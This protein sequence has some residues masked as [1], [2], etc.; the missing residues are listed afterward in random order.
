MQP[1]QREKVESL[2]SLTDNTWKATPRKVY[3]VLRIVV[4]DS[5]SG[6][7][8]PRPRERDSSAGYKDI[9]NKSGI[10]E[11]RPHSEDLSPVRLEAN[12]HN[13]GEKRRSMSTMNPKPESPNKP[14]S[15]GTRCL[16]TI[17][18]TSTCYTSFRKSLTGENVTIVDLKLAP[19]HYHEADIRRTRSGEKL[20]SAITADPHELSKL[21][22]KRPKT[23]QSRDL[24]SLGMPY[25]ESQEL[26]PYH[27]LRPNTSVTEVFGSNS[28]SCLTDVPQ[29]RKSAQTC[30]SR[31]MQVLSGQEKLCIEQRHPPSPV[32]RMPSRQDI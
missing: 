1:A 18:S 15:G 19:K 30:T 27:E 11:K 7:H 6:T 3:N 10:I 32:S 23:T 21:T 2:P 14:R 24:I 5:D 20:I 4:P 13:S 16:R 25:N 31:K 28:S 9:R 12:R 26:L 17:N 8:K 29:L 22:S